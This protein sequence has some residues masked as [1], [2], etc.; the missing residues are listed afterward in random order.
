MIHCVLKGFLG[1]SVLPSELLADVPMNKKAVK[2]YVYIFRWTSWNLKI[3]V[4]SVWYFS[5]PPMPPPTPP[6]PPPP[7]PA[8]FIT[9]RHS[10]LI[11]YSCDGS[12]TPLSLSLS[13]SLIIIYLQVLLL[14][15]CFVCLFLFSFLLGVFFVFFL[16]VCCCF[17]RNYDVF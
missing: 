2:W 11:P 16:C 15:C 1:G 10:P 4:I 5:I 8:Y 13:L 7:A 6:P 14:F 3:S 12:N 9:Y 17:Y